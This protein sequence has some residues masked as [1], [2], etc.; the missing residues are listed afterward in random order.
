MLRMVLVMAGLVALALLAPG[1]GVAQA[2]AGAATTTGVSA[3]TATAPAGQVPRRLRV[4]GGLAAIN[5]YT[6]VEEPFW[7]REL[8]KL[9][10]GRYAAEIVPF[11]RAG[12]RGQDL[13]ELM[14]SGVVPFGNML[15]SLVAD[16]APDL[17]AADLAGLNP[18][19]NSM[20]R[21]V[22]AFRPYLER[23]LRER[24]GVE[25]LA[26]YVYPAQV[27][28]CTKPIKGLRSLA[29]RRIRTSSVSQA[30]LVEA[31]GARPIS[32][33]FAEIIA[34]LRAGNI[35]CAVTGTMSG[36][37]IGLHAHTSHLHTMA[38]SWGMAVFGAHAPT[39]AALPADLKTL[40]QRELPLLERRVWD[41]SDRETGEGVACNAGGA[42][43]TAPPPETGRPAMSIVQADADDRRLIADLF[44]RVVQP[45]WLKR[46]GT[47]CSPVWETTLAP[48][49]SQRARER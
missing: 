5:Q 49:L 44:A 33:P 18:D 34:N 13:L 37:T 35:D 23:Q 20:R 25:V 28:Y 43:C 45:R 30:D 19:M 22:A 17:G 14:Q 16:K 46:C 41:D 8:Q 39:W 2:P 15:V 40:L 36:Y 24:W 48:V 11:D 26:I 1:T 3:A 12:I 9:S 10:G 42:S 21:S 47:S 27:L 29:G 31:L 32:T 38:L 7:S 6:R 4:V